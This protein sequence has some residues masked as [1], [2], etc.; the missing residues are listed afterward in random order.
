VR[1]S[2]AAERQADQGV[3]RRR[4]GGG[5]DAGGRLRVKELGR[6]VSVSWGVP[7]R[8]EPMRAM[9]RAR[10]FGEAVRIAEAA[11]EETLLA[12]ERA[13]GREVELEAGDRG[14]GLERLK[15]GVDG[16]EEQFDVGGGLGQAETAVV[17]CLVFK[18]EGEVDG[19]GDVVGGGEFE[20]AR[21][22]S[23]RR[24]MK[25]SGSRL[26]MAF[27]NSKAAEKVCGRLTGCRG[28]VVPPVARCQRARPAA[29]KRRTISSRG[30]A[31][32]SP[33]VRRPH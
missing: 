27:S 22:S 11:V 6:W 17:A 24:S 32:R 16:A 9:A 3:E 26:S 7:T 8:S 19:G 18:C 30:R 20:R 14:R 1:W 15:M 33:M 29:P 31:V 10:V 13:G 28:R 21:R 2:V 23:R 25:R 4:R 5:D 12:D